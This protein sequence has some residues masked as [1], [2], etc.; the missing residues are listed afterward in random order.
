MKTN[1]RHINPRPQPNPRQI[2]KKKVRLWPLLL[3]FS[4]VGLSVGWEVRRFD[5]YNIDFF[6]NPT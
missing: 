2:R 1:E 5:T 3:I 4:C 6:S